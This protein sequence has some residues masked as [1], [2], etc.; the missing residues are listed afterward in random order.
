VV[1][2]LVDGRIER[3][4]EDDVHAVGRDVTEAGGGAGGWSDEVADPITEA[5][6]PA[7]V[8]VAVDVGGELIRRW[9]NQSV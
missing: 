2:Q 5:L 1:E 3:P 4:G 7:P 9:T 6:C 8:M